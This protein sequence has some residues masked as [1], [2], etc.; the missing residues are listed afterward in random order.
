MAT[1][2]TA[3]NDFISLSYCSISRPG[4]VRWFRRFLY[5]GKE[6]NTSEKEQGEERNLLFCFPG[7]LFPRN[8]GLMDPFRIPVKMMDFKFRQ[9]HWEPRPCLALPCLARARAPWHSNARCVRPS[10]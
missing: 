7:R 10:G 4:P 8:P 9:F 5:G 1:V 6:S 3:A 2:D